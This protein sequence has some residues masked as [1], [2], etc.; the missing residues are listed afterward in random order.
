LECSFQAVFTGFLRAHHLDPP[1]PPPVVIFKFVSL[2]LPPAH[3][4]L[5]AAGQADGFAQAL[6]DKT[7]TGSGPRPGTLGQGR[8]TQETYSR[9][10]LERGY[11]ET[12]SRIGLE[13][14]YMETYSRIG[15]ERGYMKTYSRIGLRQDYENLQSYCDTTRL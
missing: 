6:A 2:P 11:M 3:G 13:R 9:I 5:C 4:L 12:Y 1:V 14:G 8:D 15:L 10:G 7:E